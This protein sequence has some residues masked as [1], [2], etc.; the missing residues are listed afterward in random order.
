MPM[1]TNLL[2]ALKEGVSK[3]GLEILSNPWRVRALLLDLAA[4]EPRSQKTAL[5]FSLDMG[6]GTGGH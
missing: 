6:A 2:K 4:G 5:I 3:Y 1:N